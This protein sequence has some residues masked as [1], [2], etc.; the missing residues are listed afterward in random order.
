[1]IHRIGGIALLLLFVVGCSGGGEP[2]KIIQYTDPT[3]VTGIALYEGFAW[4][5]TPGGLIRW[6]TSRSE[7]ILYT[8]S[9]GLASNVLSD[10]IVDGENRLWIASDQGVIQMRP[11]GW[12]QYTRSE[13]LPSN[14]VNDLALDREGR[15]WVAT[16]SGVASFTN[17]RFS[18]LGDDEG[19]GRQVVNVIYFDSG[20]NLWV[21]TDEDGI[22][23]RI[24]GEWGHTTT[25]RGLVSN[26][27]VTISESWD[28][29]IFAGSWSG[30][31]G[32]T[33]DG[34]LTVSTF[35]DLGTV[36]IRHLGKSS[37]HLWCF[38]GNGV[39]GYRG[40]QWVNYLERDGLISNDVLSGLVIDDSTIYAGTSLG[41]SLIRDDAFQ[42]YFIPNS[43]AGHNYIS[44]ATDPRGRIWVG[45]WENGLNVLDQG[46]WS[47][48]FATIDM[49]LNTVRGIVV[50]GDNEMVFNT[51]N[52]VVFMHGSEFELQNR[53]RGLP[54]DDVRCGVYDQQGRYW[55]GTDTGVG[56]LENGRWRRIRAVNGLPS[57]D[58]WSCA[59]GPDGSVWFGTTAGIVSFSGN[60]M[61][62]HTSQLGI[63]PPDVRSILVQ[64]DDVLFGTNDG[65]LLVYDGEDWDVHGNRYLDTDKGIHAMAADPAGTIYLGTNG[66]GVIMLHDGNTR[67]IG[68][69]DGLPSNYVRSMLYYEDN[70]WLACYGGAAT[71]AVTM[72]GE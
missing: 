72:P 43:I 2:V 40:V 20:D 49:P 19:P 32:W 62:D 58:V 18:S 35:S 28:R 31:G 16:D 42:N 26:S 47:Q 71:I 64:G 44:L 3:D 30:L 6:D 46:Y 51:L 66:D 13:G 39:H 15:L 21:G 38:T 41:L 34:W 45:T 65:R 10:V 37:Q 59:L 5:S 69:E 52:G 67:R 22:Y 60:T 50:T 12:R 23:Y 55:I 24:T 61:T 7:Y 17:G 68:Q 48:P 57:D 4:C 11:E 53:A 56:Y 36:D 25:Y 33:G 8:T 29:N 63:E 27:I 9:D 54:G 14:E 70:I 1:M